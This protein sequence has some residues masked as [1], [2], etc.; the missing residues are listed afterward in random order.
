MA[1]MKRRTILFATGKQIKLFGNSVGIG[2]SLE[3][4]EGYTPNILSAN[5]E[6]DPDDSSLLV[7]NPYKLTREEVLELADYMM[8]LWLQLKDN[9]RKSGLD[10]PKIF[11]KDPTK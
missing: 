1:E 7:N 6:N 11:A 4:G 3:V 10:N 8:Q 2:K 9:I 5:T